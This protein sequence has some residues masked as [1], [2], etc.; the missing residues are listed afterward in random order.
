MMK[1]HLIRSF[2]I[3]SLLVLTTG[4]GLMAWALAA[5][6]S[7][8]F[9]G[10]CGILCA[11]G[12]CLSRDP[13]NDPIRHGLMLGFIWGTVPLVFYLWP[14]ALF[15]V[16]TGYREQGALY[17]ENG[18]IFFLTAVLGMTYWSLVGSLTVG[19]L[20]GAVIKILTEQFERFHLFKGE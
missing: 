18:P 2:S 5:P 16:L 3:R 14:V 13:K 10:G 9:F 6:F 15:R 20:V 4:A 19:V 17:D 7:W 12:V 11:L 8:R 1:L